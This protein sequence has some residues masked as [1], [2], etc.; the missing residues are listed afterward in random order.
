MLEILND[1]RMGDRVGAYEGAGYSSTG[2]YR[3]M[4]NCLM[5]RNTPGDRSYCRVCEDAIVRMIDYYCG[6]G[7][8]GQ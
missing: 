1:P 4:L 7:P 2:L 8:T 3:P 6:R 5:F